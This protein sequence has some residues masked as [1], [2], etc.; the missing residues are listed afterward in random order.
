MKYG[1]TYTYN[2][3]VEIEYDHIF[4]KD[5]VIEYLQMCIKIIPFSYSLHI[6]MYFYLIEYNYTLEFIHGR[7]LKKTAKNSISIRFKIKYYVIVTYL[8]IQNDFFN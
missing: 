6:K 5:N 7:F 1:I 2:E 8:R 3:S 4:N